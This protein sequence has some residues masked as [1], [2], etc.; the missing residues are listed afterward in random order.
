MKNIFLP[1]F[2]FFLLIISCKSVVESNNERNTIESKL[3]LKNSKWRLIK[4]NGK[5]IVEN[6][7]SKR[8]FGIIFTTEGIFSAFV[9]CNSISGNYEIK[10]DKNRIIFS[11]IITT[12]MACEEMNTE[13]ELLSILDITD[14]YN[15]DGKTLK[16][17]K[18]RMSHLAEFEL[19][20]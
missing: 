14:N 6:E 15:F 10:E 17:N 16:L 7:N 3:E 19:I 12:M 4:L 18:A 2:A 5:N 20:K 8:N 1:I 13:Q 11:K 9:G